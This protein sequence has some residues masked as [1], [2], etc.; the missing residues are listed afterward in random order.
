MA[1]S[2]RKCPKC[3]KWLPNN[4]YTVYK[5]PE[6]PTD[7]LLSPPKKEGTDGN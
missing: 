7:S 6:A 4:P 1:P 2:D 5:C 3:G